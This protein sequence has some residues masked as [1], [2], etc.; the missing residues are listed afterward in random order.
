VFDIASEDWSFVELVGAIQAAL[1]SRETRR[2]VMA[3][4]VL[5]RTL[6]TL[7]NGIVLPY[8]R[9]HIKLLSDTRFVGSDAEVIST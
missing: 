1:S 6:H 2:P 8:T 7:R 3:R 9:P 5:Q 4:I